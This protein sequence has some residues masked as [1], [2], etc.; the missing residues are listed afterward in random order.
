MKHANLVPGLDQSADD[1]RPDEPRSANDQYLH[2]LGKELG[3]LRPVGRTKADPPIVQ[4]GLEEN[5]PRFFSLA[6]AHAPTPDTPE[7]GRKRIDLGTV[8]QHPPFMV[9]KQTAV[10][11]MLGSY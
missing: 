2:F 8:V 1:M 11:I 9:M 7:V 10:V 4:V 5:D 6:V 3:P